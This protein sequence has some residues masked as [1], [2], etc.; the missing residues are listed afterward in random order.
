YPP[1]PQE[2]AIRLEREDGTG[3]RIRNFG[4]T[5]QNLQLRDGRLVSVESLVNVAGIQNLEGLGGV[6]V[7]ARIRQTQ[8]LLQ[9]DSELSAPDGTLLV[10][11]AVASTPAKITVDATQH[12]PA[13]RMLSQVK[14]FLSDLNFDLGDV[15]PQ[16]RLTQM[17]A[18]ANFESGA[19]LDANAS[20]QLDGGAIGSS[21]SADLQF[22]VTAPGSVGPALDLFVEH[23]PEPNGPFRVVAKVHVPS[24]SIHARTRENGDIDVDAN[25][26]G[27][28][29]ARIFM[30][31]TPPA[32]PVLDK[33][34]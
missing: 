8:G 29:R 11:T 3:I 2:S 23:S 1:G 22:H 24:V 17:H 20:I 26:N 33:A 25:L 21:D 19:L 18:E 10:E 14:P 30:S 32:S 28:A 15:N 9:L 6:D 12:V 16:A 5:L 13:D 27:E 34:F 4:T 31:G 7:Q